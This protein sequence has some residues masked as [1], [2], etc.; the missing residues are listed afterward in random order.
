MTRKDLV[1]TLVRLG[2]SI[3]IED[4][5]GKPVFGRDDMTVTVQDDRIVIQEHGKMEVLFMEFLCVVN[6]SLCRTLGWVPT[7]IGNVRKQPTVCLIE[8]VRRDSHLAKLRKSDADQA[9]DLLSDMI[10]ELGHAL[11]SDPYTR[12]RIRAWLI[13]EA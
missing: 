5:E 11:V 4:C 13:Q 12:E 9:A 3:R 7:D 6:G 2:F 10:S 8:P 1:D